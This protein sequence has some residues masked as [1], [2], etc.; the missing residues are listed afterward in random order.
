MGT[1]LLTGAADTIVSALTRQSL[2]KPGAE[3][4]KISSAP[5]FYQR[6]DCNSQ[7]VVKLP[8][9]KTVCKACVFFVIAS[10]AKQSY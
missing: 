10:E 2:T 6:G 3:E 7:L 5:D 8:S 9:I 1:L 4:S